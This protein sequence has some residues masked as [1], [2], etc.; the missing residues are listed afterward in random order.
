[1]QLHHLIKYQHLKHLIIFLPKKVNRG[2][3]LSAVSSAFID[4]YRA[5][6]AKK[7]GRTI[8]NMTNDFGYVREFVK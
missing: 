1:M 4:L 5:S 8:G 6:A 3:I 2:S 7:S